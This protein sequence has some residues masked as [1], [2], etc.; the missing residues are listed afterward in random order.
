LIATTWAGVIGRTGRT[1]SKS[2]SGVVLSD[3][4]NGQVGVL[5]RDYPQ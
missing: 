1:S 5:L 2:T 3:Q 4:P